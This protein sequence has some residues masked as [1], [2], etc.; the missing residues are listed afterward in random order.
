MLPEGLLEGRVVAEKRSEWN[1]E[2][3]KP[4]APSSA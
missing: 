3:S 4:N 2:K 1:K